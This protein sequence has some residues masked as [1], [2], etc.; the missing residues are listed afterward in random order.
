L[1]DTD[2]GSDVVCDMEI[3]MH[4]DDVEFMLYDCLYY[5]K[6]IISMHFMG[7]YEKLLQVQIGISNIKFSYQSYFSIDMLQPGYM[8]GLVFTKIDSPY[9]Y[10][11]SDNL[12]IWK[13]SKTTVDLRYCDGNLYSALYKKDRSF[14]KFVREG[15]VH[16]TNVNGM[17]VEVYYDTTGFVYVRDRYDKK[18][19]NAT[20]VVKDILSVTRNIS[21]ASLLIDAQMRKT[22]YAKDKVLSLYR[23]FSDVTYVHF[24]RGRRSNLYSTQNLSMVHKFMIDKFQRY[25]DDQDKKNS[26]ASVTYYLFYLKK[27]ICTRFVDCAVHGANKT[28]AY[29]YYDKVNRIKPVSR[30]IHNYRNESDMMH[31]VQDEIDSCYR[32][33]DG[34]IVSLC[35]RDEEY[36]LILF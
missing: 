35:D 36:D 6:S 19:P 17:I 32:F 21:Y 13:S 23:I 4:G 29:E 2:F 14:D 28:C 30:C 31:S 15:H 11:M 33:V 26:L 5:N 3:L 34:K 20:P 16:W 9:V 10:G 12:F 1:G 24:C 18:M 7:R 8:E 22:F 27:D 25:R